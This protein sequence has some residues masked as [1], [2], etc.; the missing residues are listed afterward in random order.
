M[1]PK[2]GVKN[3]NYFFRSLGIGFTKKNGRKKFTSNFICKIIYWWIEWL[4]F[5]YFFTAEQ[6][7]C[8]VKWI[9]YTR[10]L[11]CWELF[12]NERCFCRS[13]KGTILLRSKY[14]CR[15][16]AQ[17]FFY[18]IPHCLLWNFSSRNTVIYGNKS[19]IASAPHEMSSIDRCL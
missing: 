16:E 10:A 7:I 13:R 18:C 8:I 6:N 14:L 15:L 1:S 11:R 2:F 17:F 9:F 3:A 19:L 4:I 12:S 5:F